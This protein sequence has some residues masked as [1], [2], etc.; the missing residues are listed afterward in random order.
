VK[1]TPE[2]LPIDLGGRKQPSGQYR[3][4]LC[5]PLDSKAVIS[6]SSSVVVV[7]ALERRRR[8]VI[9]RLRVPLK[10]YRHAS[11]SPIKPS[12]AGPLYQVCLTV[13][14]STPETP[15]FAPK[16]KPAATT[17]QVHDPVGRRKIPAFSTNCS[18]A[19]GTCASEPPPIT[20]LTSAFTLHL[21]DPSS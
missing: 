9:D 18:L 6:W 17:T 1:S 3:R 19:L 2:Q 16:F 11:R 21:I 5:I 15:L 14:T 20:G 10:Y 7:E 12:I 13:T 4:E 8:I